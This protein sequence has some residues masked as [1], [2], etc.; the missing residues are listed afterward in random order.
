MILVVDS[1]ATKTHWMMCDTSGKKMREC[2]T[3][4]INPYYQSA[5][6]IV[7][8]L[9]ANEYAEFF[10]S[11]VPEVVYFYG[12]GCANVSNKLLIEEALSAFFSCK[13]FVQSDLLGAARAL[14]GDEAGIACILGTG[15]S[16]CYYDGS[17]IVQDLPSLGFILGDWCSG[18]SLG[19]RLTADYY[20]KRLPTDLYEDFKNRFNIDYG[21]FMNSVYRAA[22]PNRYLASFVPFLVDHQTSS[23]VK[24]LLKEEY[25]AL[26]YNYLIVY[27]RYELPIGV[28][29]SVGYFFRHLLTP[30]FQESFV[31]VA[32]FLKDP[33]LKLCQY[34]LHRFDA[35][36]NYK[37]RTC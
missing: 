26:W 33:L 24:T 37:N 27:S 17:T 31:C 3:S 16:V 36:S 25:L 11:D 32:D 9:S 8:M 20:C 7:D 6:S 4:G 10:S 23:Y 12:A 15:A 34:H 13:V 29:G 22:Y 28:V 14:F 1:G 2:I 30:L 5:C 18:A 35:F 21:E 19:K